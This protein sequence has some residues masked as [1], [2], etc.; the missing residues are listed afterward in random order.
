[1]FV[2]WLEEIRRFKPSTVSRRLSVVTCFYRTCVIDA[3]LDASPAAYVRRPPVSSESPTL[4]LSHLQFEAMIVAARSSA[5]LFDFA[6][7]AMLGLLGLD[8]LGEEHGHRVLRVLG[9]G[10]KLAGAGRHAAGRAGGAGRLRPAG[11]VDRPEGRSAG[12]RVGVRDGAGSFAAHVRA[13]SVEDGPAGSRGYACGRGASA[14]PFSFGL[15]LGPGQLQVLQH[16]GVASAA[17]DSL[18]MLAQDH[19]EAAAALSQLASRHRPENTR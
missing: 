3:V 16:Q 6:L 4:G 8:D 13:A 1:M 12:H 14:R 5:N 15:G 11:D 17:L 7:V 2:R 10:T 18:Q 9:K 19:P